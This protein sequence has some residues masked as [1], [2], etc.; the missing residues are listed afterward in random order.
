MDAEYVF[1][2]ILGLLPYRLIPSTAM[3]FG[4]FPQL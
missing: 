2:L 4:G 3:L 1:S